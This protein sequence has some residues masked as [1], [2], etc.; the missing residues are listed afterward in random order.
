VD[1]AEIESEHLEN[2]AS[3]RRCAERIQAAWPGFVSKREQRLEQQRRL[4][5][6]SEKVAENIMEDL[7]TAVLDWPFADF[8]NQVE[9]ADIV[10]TDHGIKR[11]VVEVKRPGSLAWSR[12][13]VESTLEMI[14]QEARSNLLD[15][16]LVQLFVDAKVYEITGRD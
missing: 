13:A 6:A 8:N 2:L 14:G 16:A 1:P 3:H 10:R 7:F 5:E 9:H 4:G 11:L 12:R 15:P